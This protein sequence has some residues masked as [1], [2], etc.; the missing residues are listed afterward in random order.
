MPCPSSTE[1]TDN[2]VASH[3]VCGDKKD[4]QMNLSILGCT[5][6]LYEFVG[7]SPLSWHLDFLFDTIPKGSQTDRSTGSRYKD[8]RRAS[9]LGGSVIIGSVD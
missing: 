9:Y 6:R 5:V 2:N 3:K 7:S 1:S 4:S 8:A